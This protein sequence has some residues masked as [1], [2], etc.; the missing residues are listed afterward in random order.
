MKDQTVKLQE[1][2]RDLGEV[3]SERLD[4]IKNF[5]KSILYQAPS[6][7]NKEPRTLKGI[8][9]G[10]GFEKILSLE[11]EIKDTRKEI[12]KRILSRKLK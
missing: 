4:E 10:K 1:I 8:W 2:L 7:K 5:I 11:E 9:A 3:P 12:T 6:K